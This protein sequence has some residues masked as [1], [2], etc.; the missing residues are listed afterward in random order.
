MTLERTPV[1]IE[2]LWARRWWA[3]WAFT[4]LLMAPLVRAHDQ[5]LIFVSVEAGP[6]EGEFVER[7]LL[8]WDTLLLLAPMG[9]LPPGPEALAAAQQAIEAGVWAQAPVYREQE[10]CLRRS[11][12]SKLSDAVVELSAAFDCPPGE[13][14]QVFRFLSILP[15][16]YRIVLKGREDGFSPTA[17]AQ[18]QKQT[19]LLNGPPEPLRPMGLW[20]WVR[21]GVEHL[22][23]GVDHL[24]FLLALVV[25]QATWRQV[26]TWVTSFTLAH[27]LTLLLA[28]RG[29][30]RFS[31]EGFR[32]VELA[33][34]VSLVAVALENL[35][36]TGLRQRVWVTFGFGLIHG[37][38]FASVLQAYEL[39]PSW[40][41]GLVGF[42]L[43]VEL[44]QAVLVA[45]V[46]PLWAYWRRRN[47]AALIAS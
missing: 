29:V 7:L 12:F 38:G 6:G 23:E 37:L 4:G 22:F 45:L 15:A 47:E 18:G 13:K 42:N 32:W 28:S 19:L 24:A 39:G 31:E 3:L 36:Q 40:V 21:L 5:D 1:R 17:S 27:S 11:T 43:G 9:Q 26:L 34:A 33:I 46:F 41:T 25:V 2:N 10:V 8:T 14:R 20:L 30:L 16:H 44:G 35:L